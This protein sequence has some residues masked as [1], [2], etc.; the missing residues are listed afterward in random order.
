MMPLPYPAIDTLAAYLE[1]HPNDHPFYD[2]DDFRGDPVRLRSWYTLDMTRANPIHGRPAPATQSW[3]YMPVILDALLGHTAATP[4][5]ERPFCSF[6][7]FAQADAAHYAGL[8]LPFHSYWDIVTCYKRLF[9]DNGITFALIRRHFDGPNHI[10][11]NL[12]ER[13]INAENDGYLYC[14]GI[15]NAFTGAV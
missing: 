11:G 3:L 14:L 7:P 10:P 2:D 1:A 9:E 8:P 13:L 12:Q 5:V 15:F 6:S 4:D